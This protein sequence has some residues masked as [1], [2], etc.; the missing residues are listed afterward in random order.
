MKIHESEFSV[1]KMCKTLDVAP[2]HYYQ[3]RNGP[4][5]PRAKG[6]SELTRQIES[7]FESTDHCYGSP[8]I[9]HQLRQDGW[10]CGENRVAKLM[11]INGIRARKPPRF[12]P[13]TT[14]WNHPYLFVPGNLQKPD[15][16][17]GDGDQDGERKCFKSE[18]IRALGAEKC[19]SRGTAYG[20]PQILWISCSCQRFPDP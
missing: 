7:I 3:H 1:R 10:C 2:S 18:R 19:I 4:P 5:G 16:P 17:V 11:R 13:A 15:A 6:N 8:R 20:V 9:T 14:D 12:V